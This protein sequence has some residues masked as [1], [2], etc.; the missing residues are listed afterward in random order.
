MDQD[1]DQDQTLLP[2]VTWP[3]VDALHDAIRVAR[4]RLEAIDARYRNAEAA[5][6][7][8]RQVELALEAQA[9][10]LHIGEDAERV[11][12]LICKLEEPNG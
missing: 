6:N 11:V 7:R 1:Q 8:D 3:R 10:A 2:A 9:L 5:P 12:A 4:E